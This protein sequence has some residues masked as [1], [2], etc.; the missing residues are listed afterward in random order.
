MDL[1]LAGRCYVV[2]GGSK[3]IGRAIVSTLLTEGARVATCARDL[4]VLR[5]SWRDRDDGRL[6]LDSRD[7]RD[8]AGMRAFVDRAAE[9]FGR[10]DGVVANAGV[11][12]PGT[13][14]FTSADVWSG[15]FDVK[16]LGTLNLIEPAVR[17]LERSDAGSIVVMNGVTAHA[18]EHNMAAVGAA[19]AALANAM[20][21]LTHQLAPK[22]IRV[23][24]V[25]L[26]AIVTERQ[27]L[28]HT[29]SGSPLDFAGWCDEQA[30]TR[31]I[32]LG[33]L[34]QPEEVAPAVAFLL[35]PLA[36]YLTGAS[37]DVAGGLGARP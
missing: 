14:L 15:Q 31:G 28:K 4:A 8:A 6:L 5:E 35:S 21:L 30:R 11:G 7:V 10:L 16:V 37:V 34:G 24:V 9:E 25:N 22:G 26:G 20:A 33:R 32:P 17:H 27:H 13:V 3:G 19:R 36:S 2:T 23:N 12:A 18:P 1:A 29:A